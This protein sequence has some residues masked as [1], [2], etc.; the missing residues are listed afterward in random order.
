RQLPL[1][2]DVQPTRDTP[3]DHI[4]FQSPHLQIPLGILQASSDASTREHKI[5][6]CF[7]ASGEFGFAATVRHAGFDASEVA[8]TVRSE[9]TEITVVVE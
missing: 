6:L 3:L 9:T 8:T 4:L 2:L 5:G 1:I 7:L